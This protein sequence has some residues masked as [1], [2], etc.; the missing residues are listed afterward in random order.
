M[1]SHYGF[2]DA[3]ERA[4]ARQDLLDLCAELDQKVLA[5]GRDYLAA[6]G[7]MPRSEF[8][9]R[10]GQTTWTGDDGDAVLFAITLWHTYSAETHPQVFV[11][12]HANLAAVS[13]ANVARLRD[14]LIRETGYGVS[15]QLHDAAPD[16][17]RALQSAEGA[18]WL[19]L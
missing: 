5:I 10:Q 13:I 1:P 3:D 18:N 9:R 16:L 8:Q 11:N 19:T 14:V 17:V 12:M 4:R 6:C 2:E 7:M 15:G